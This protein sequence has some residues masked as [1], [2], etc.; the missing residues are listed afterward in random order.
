MANGKIL[1]EDIID[2]EGI[3]RS[4]TEVQQ[5]L[6]NLKDALKGIEKEMQAEVKISGLDEIK[7]LAPA[8]QSL[9]D[10]M[11]RLKTASDVN[12]QAM[13]ALKA[14]TNAAT[15]E[16]KQSVAADN[17]KAAALKAETA[18]L[19][20][21][22]AAKKLAAE[23]EKER[24]V[25]VKS[26]TAELSAE[27]I[28]LKELIA[29][30]NA[31]AQALRNA[32]NAVQVQGK[33][34]NELSASYGA[35]KKVLNEVN[36][37]MVNSSQTGYKAVQEK[38]AQLYE[39][40]NKYQQST[41][42][43]QMNVGQYRTAF[44]GLGFSIQ[45]VLREVPSALNVQQFFLAISNNIPM[46]V[47]QMKLFNTEQQNIKKNLEEI[48]KNEGK[49][50][51]AYEAMANKQI[52][53]GKK[54]AQS[55][56]NW[57][58]ALIAVLMLLRKY[59]DDIVNWFK[60]IIHGAE[61]VLS[62][63]KQLNDVNKGAAASVGEL[64]AQYKAQQKE[65]KTLTSA[66]K[67][68][69]VNQQC[70]IWNE[71]GIAVNSVNNAE[72][73]YSEEG[74]K[75][76]IAAIDKRARSAAALE[77]ATE[78]YKKAFELQNEAENN[79]K[80]GTV[81]GFFPNVISYILSAT[82]VPMLPAIVSQKQYENKTN[83]AE[84]AKLEADNYINRF[85]DLDALGNT[86]SSKGSKGSSKNEPTVQ[87]VTDRYWESEEALINAYRKGYEKEYALAELARDKALEANEDN[88]DEQLTKLD[89]NLANKF[90]TQEEYDKEAQKLERQHNNIQ[91]GIY[92]DYQT[93][94]DDITA[95]MNDEQYKKRADAE[96]DNI[97][98]LTDA[99]DHQLKAVRKRVKSVEDERDKNAELIDNIAILEKKMASLNAQEVTTTESTEAQAKAIGKTTEEIKKLQSQMDV[100]QQ[101]KN[102]GSI[103]DMFDSNMFITGGMKSNKGSFFDKFSGSKIK[104]EDMDSETVDAF[105][106]NNIGK[107][108]DSAKEA[109]GSLYDEAKNYVSD[110]LNNY[111]DAWVE[112]YQE[113]ADLAKEDTENAKTNWETQQELLANGYASNVETAWKE[114]NEKKAIQKQAEAEAE[115]AQ[116]TQ[117]AISSLESGASL[118]V[119]IANII[120]LYSGIPLGGVGIAAS[121]IAG[122][123]ATYI[124]YKSQIKS[125]AN[126]GEGMVEYV[127][128]GSHSSGN[129]VAMGYDGSGRERRVEGG[130][131]IAVFNKRAVARY[132]RDSVESIVRNI[133]GMRYGQIERNIIQR[134]GIVANVFSQSS[135]RVS[136]GKVESGLAEL[137]S[138]GAARSYVDGDGNLVETNGN[139]TRKTIRR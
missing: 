62:Y 60:K 41:G 101:F 85:V 18:E 17:A 34:Y 130:E 71:L 23:A 49:A 8:V 26:G 119:A 99:Y 28:A 137:V 19:Y 39:A 48:E 33:S 68:K 44:D 24:T 75:S 54:I 125:V 128:G 79:K 37:D 78:K 61:D 90:I 139:F 106:D 129:D 110:L 93:K 69:F 57:Q 72:R 2:V 126:Y 9:A 80:N 16:S 1:A 117:S 65:W 113:K 42:K 35:L 76:V 134:N 12:K 45:Q 15:E 31:S 121:V 123:L 47:D 22:V 11:A 58:T 59:G 122:M 63:M 4:L 74:T 115:R 29:T 105:F 87:S 92:K 55:I 132:G 73:F 138:Q 133:N 124:S 81:S 136:L 14:E 135:P 127:N 36:V 27:V 83:E 7:T 32:S 116:K 46:V 89:E 100:S 43:W 38:L 25:H 66:D 64:T 108:S 70:W 102:Y 107:W 131:E 94:Y 97:N 5:N 103:S 6:G 3:K 51:A 96:I 86:G 82:N 10:A 88:W 30:Q 40:M 52:S 109:W 114:Y 53:M 84:K 20:K 118:S 56:F 91:L 67:I 120:K 111:L 104:A 95:K 77:L 13:A 21:E 98:S 112:Y 50:S